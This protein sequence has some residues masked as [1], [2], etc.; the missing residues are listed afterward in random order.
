MAANIDDK[1]WERLIRRI[2]EGKCTP[3]LGAGVCDGILP[4]GSDLAKDFATAYSYPLEDSHDLARVTQ[5]VAVTEDPMEP[6]EKVSNRLRG[7]AP[8]NFDENDEPHAV[9]AHLPFPIYITTNYDSFMAKALRHIKR[10]P[11]Q[12]VCRWNSYLTRYPLIY[13]VDPDF[14][15]TVANPLVFHLHGCCDIPESIV[16]TEDDY[17]DFLV[18]LS[19]GDELLPLKIQKAFGGTSLLFLGYRLSDW[20]FRVLFRQ[21]VTYL[22]GN[23]GR[24]HLAVQIVPGPGICEDGIE[25]IQRY[26]NRYYGKLEIKVYWGKCRE[27]A[28]ELKHRWR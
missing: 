15:P 26:L 13:P 17:L 21:L 22:E 18:K 12:E 1:D 16:L 20:D 14:N 28:A 4:L 3:F 24:S 6:K 27:F 11:K 19:R 25:K 7:I 8:P 23:L 10:D 2:K 5:Y 9:L